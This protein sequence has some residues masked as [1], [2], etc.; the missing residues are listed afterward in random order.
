MNERY[1]CFYISDH[2]FG[3]AARSIAIIRGILNKDKQANIIIKTSKPLN[4]IKESLNKYKDRVIYDYIQN[5]VGLILNKSSISLNRNLLKQKIKKWVLSWSKYIEKEISFLK[6]Y[7]VISIISDITPQ[8]FIVAKK[9]NIKNLGICNFTWYD[10]YKDIYGEANF[11]D[12]I[13]E[14]YNMCDK[15]F[16]YPFAVDSSFYNNKTDNVGLLSRSID[17][18]RV[19]EIKRIITK[20]NKPIIYFGIGK[21]VDF[22]YLGNLDIWE[23]DKY[24]FLLSSG[25]L[26]KG[27]NIYK[28][29]KSETETQNYIAAC[30]LVITK[31]GWS[32]IAE[33]IIAQ[34]PLVVIKRDE[35]VEDRNTL[36]LIE[37]NNL[38]ISREAHDINSSFLYDLLENNRIKKVYE[39]RD[40][41]FMNNID[42]IV[43]KIIDYSL[44]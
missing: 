2:G 35:I 25:A 5:D 8:A 44:K 17:Y 37:Q 26:I 30:D 13:K 20:D 1:I 42:L 27:K 31:A 3:H 22:D 41:K 29:P 18:E 19:K 21:S 32:T 38:G 10:I 43:N 28:I 24:T 39:S 9:L 36:R 14:A 23:N 12:K 33:S 16:I 4:F 34:V 6:K 15:Y 40:T 11:L 7:N